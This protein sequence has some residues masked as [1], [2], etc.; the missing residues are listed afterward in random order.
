MPVYPCPDCGTK[1]KPANP[2]PPGKKIRCPECGNVFAP[3][4]AGA[5][6]ARAAKPERPAAKPGTP[7][8]EPGDGYAVIREETV[9][10]AEEAFSPLK[11][12]FKRSARG[13]ALVEVVKPST[14]LLASG[15]LTCVFAIV[16]ALWAIWPMIFK[17]EMVQQDDKSKPAIFRDASDKRRFKELT[18][19]EWRERWMF[20]GGFVFQFAWGA[21]VCGGASKMHTLETYP[22]AVV[23]SVMALAGPGAP[24]GVYLL[25]DALKTDDAYW[26][27]VG[28]LLLAL[29]GVP[30]S[31]WCLS[32]L[33]KP[34]VRAG[35]A[36]EKPEDFHQG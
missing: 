16:G 24:A 13:P 36:E 21:L 5:E 25:T 29:P 20:L 8:E 33:R 19:D 14:W 1:L 11:E 12:R 34:A 6:A 9:R 31:F 32:T 22:L 30:I 7:F 15:I 27:F 2:V 17:V 35:F 28:V 10:S 3:A 26:A 23:G 4:A 18:E